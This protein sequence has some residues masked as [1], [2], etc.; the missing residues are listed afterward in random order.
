MMMMM[1]SSSRMMMLIVMMDGTISGVAF[2][3]AYTRGDYFE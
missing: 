1:I 3:C 2:S